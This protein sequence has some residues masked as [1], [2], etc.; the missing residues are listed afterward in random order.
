MARGD[1]KNGVDGWKVVGVDSKGR[2]VFEK[3]IK[4]QE[5]R[6]YKDTA[7]RALDPMAD[8]RKKVDRGKLNSLPVEFVSV[9]FGEGGA[10][11]DISEDGNTV[12]GTYDADGSDVVMSRH[13]NEIIIAVN[14]E[15]KSVIGP[16]EEREMKM[17]H[18]EYE[19]QG[20]EINRK[21]V[22]D[23]DLS[24]DEETG[25][26]VLKMTTANGS[27]LTYK[28]SPD[29]VHATGYI[30]ATDEGGK[31]ETRE[32]AQNI[33]AEDIVELSNAIAEKGG[34]GS[35]AA[36]I[37]QAVVIGKYFKREWKKYARKPKKQFPRL[38]FTGAITKF[39]EKALRPLDD[40]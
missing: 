10:W 35:L 39:F 29:G 9:F 19:L 30:T 31:T 21:Y 14:G 25:A 5:K 36:T 17:Q 11:S 40:F 38:P 7:K 27:L 26:R 3:D 18:V 4:P 12:Y 16:P 34:K 28:I 32:I 20:E 13:G 22:S 8:M 1:K 2:P 33:P 15:V 23:V 6:R 24:T 37:G